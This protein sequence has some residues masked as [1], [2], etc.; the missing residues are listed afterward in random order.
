[1]QFGAGLRNTAVRPEA[2]VAMASLHVTSRVW[3][4]TSNLKYV[5]G[6]VESVHDKYVLLHVQI[7]LL[8][9][10]FIL[11]TRVNVFWITSRR[12]KLKTRTECMF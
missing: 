10:F 5:S 9:Y 12:L 11:V 8:F 2:K 7:L 6:I 4:K 1:M 3:L